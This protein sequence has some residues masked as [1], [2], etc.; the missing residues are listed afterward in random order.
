LKITIIIIGFASWASLPRF[1]SHTNNEMSQL[2]FLLVVV[3]GMT[4]DA[5]QIKNLMIGLIH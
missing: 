1:Q 3:C 2:F 5:L 4:Q